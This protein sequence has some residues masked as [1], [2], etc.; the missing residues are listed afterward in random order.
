MWD[1]TALGRMALLMDLV[2]RGVIGV[3]LRGSQSR[4]IDG[5]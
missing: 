4:W 2:V 5:G 3:A 1:V